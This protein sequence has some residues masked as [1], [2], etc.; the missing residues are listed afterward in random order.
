MD[1][2]FRK[3]LT[4]PGKT[5]PLITIFEHSND[6]LQ[7]ML[8]LLR[9]NQVTQPELLKLAALLHDI[10]KIEQKFDGRRWVHTPYTQAYFDVLLNDRRFQQMVAQ[11]GIN[12]ADFNRQ[13]FYA[14]LSETYEL[15]EYA[16]ESH[17]APAQSPA[18]L[19]RCK[20]IVLV[21]VADMIASAAAKGCI[22]RMDELLQ[23][24]PYGQ[25]M[26][27]L[28]ESLAQEE[29]LESLLTSLAREIH[30]I[31]LPAQFVEDELLVTAVFKAL[32]QD[33]FATSDL[34]PLMQRGNTLWVV[35]AKQRVEEALRNLTLAP[36][37]LYR[38]LY[39]EQIYSSILNNL[40]AAGAL[41]I[42]SNKY[43]LVNE[44]ITRQYATR[45]MLRRSAQQLVERHNISADE[46]SRIM[47]GRGLGV[48]ARLRALAESIPYCLTGRSA[49]YFYSNWR[50][51]SEKLFEVA[52][53]EPDMAKV[54]TYLKNPRTYVSTTSPTA[55]AFGDYDEV[56]ILHIR[57]D[58]PSLPLRAV[59][60]LKVLAPETLLCELIEIADELS[61]C[62]AAALLVAQ[63]N[64]L[65]WPLALAQLT[66]RKLIRQGG[67]LFEILNAEAGQEIV[68][69][70]LIQTLFAQVTVTPDERPYPFPFLAPA[71]T[72]ST[73]KTISQASLMNAA[74]TKAPS[75]EAQS[76]APRWGIEWRLP[77]LPLRKVL[78][79]L[80]VIHE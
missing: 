77:A 9:E 12:L 35:G 39:G 31:E 41:Q 64:A 58:L 13:A 46:I 17:H 69:A 36:D 16:C 79:D 44:N 78:A 49:A 4:L 53:P 61:V 10:G 34:F 76:L 1:D 32:E 43:I 51:T 7:V 67:C 27:N 6:V 65:D 54:Y 47:T 2:V 60:G 24:S 45:I 62:D 14:E 50:Y 55:K 63:R 3:Y 72:A 18:K 48:A 66:A 74:R 29:G 22:G 33:T 26:Y 59:K 56:V 25:S 75:A 19:R 37:R 28:L 11:I 42:D 20:P 40:P 52:I 21:A 15:L 71:A 8:Y 57:S 70:S 23:A 73:G 38:F 80:G 5:E 30:R 68:P